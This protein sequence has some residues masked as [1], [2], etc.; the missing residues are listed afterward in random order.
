MSATETF[1]CLF[2]DAFV[3]FL[4]K[5]LYLGIMMNEK[6]GHRELNVFGLGFGFGTKI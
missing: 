6:L 3:S 4:L 1:S 5:N 2:I